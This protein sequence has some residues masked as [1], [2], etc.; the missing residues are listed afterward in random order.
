MSEVRYFKSKKSESIT[1]TGPSGQRYTLKKSGP[2]R[3]V[4]NK[5]DQRNFSSRQDT[6]IE[7][8]KDGK[9][10]VTVLGNSAYKSRNPISVSSMKRE[11]KVRR[12]P[13]TAGSLSL[14]SSD[15]SSNTP[16]GSNLAGQVEGTLTGSDGQAKKRL[17]GRKNKQDG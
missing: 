2:G 15:L 13:V 3:E 8:D 5:I 14:V 6:L 7:C 1:I 17:G 11:S 16:N 4:S 10:E 9:Y 12:V